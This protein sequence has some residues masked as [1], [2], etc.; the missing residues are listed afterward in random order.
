MIDIE[1]FK[2]T[3]KIIRPFVTPSPIKY[4][5]WLSELLEAEVYMKLECLQ[6]GNSF[7]IRGATHALLKNKL[8]KKVITASGGNHGLGVAHACRQQNI[9]CLVVLPTSTSPYRL[10]LLEDLGAEIMLHGEA[11]DEANNHALKLAESD[12]ILY[13][14]PFA[15]EEVILGQGTIGLELL[16]SLDFDALLCSV[17]GG[18]LLTGIALALEAS[19][20]SDID[21]YSVET[22]G[23]DSLYQSIKAG[24][25]IELEAITSIAGT[26]GA[27][28]TVPFIFDNLNRLLSDSFVIDDRVAV[29]YILEFLN[30]EKILI[31][32]ATSC[33]IA[34]AIQNKQLFKNKKIVLIICGSNVILEEV[35]QW[36]KKFSI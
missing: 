27:K 11:W 1:Q 24:K 3:E 5:Y 13:I 26:L 25:L 16:E 32:P 12:D 30:H 6:P 23:T 34:A 33:T 19:G 17:G 4:S 18:G 29:E 15:D 31:E 9:P 2:S 20:R 28:Q 36:K 10:S 7:K 8:P 14:H 21:L 35:E 22:L